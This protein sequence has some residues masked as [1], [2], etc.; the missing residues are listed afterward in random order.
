MGSELTT[1]FS[2]KEKKCIRAWN[3]VIDWD[4]NVDPDFGENHFMRP[5]PVKPTETMQA[6]GYI[7]NRLAG[8]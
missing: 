7:E 6:E 1:I 8:F 3:N 5:R 2:R 4:L